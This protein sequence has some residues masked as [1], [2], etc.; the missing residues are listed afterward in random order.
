MLRGDDQGIAR[1]VP[2]A[3]CALPP[4][5][6]ATAVRAPSEA[7]SAAWSATVIP[8]LPWEGPSA[9]TSR[10][11]PSAVWPTA[12]REVRLPSWEPVKPSPEVGTAFPSL[13]QQRAAA[14]GRDRARRAGRRGPGTGLR[15]GRG[16]TPRPMP[17]RRSPPR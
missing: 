3:S 1:L 8:G 14:E 10:V 11:V 4:A 9:V 17:A 15:A 5:S 2:T 16:G 13:H 12:E 7:S 6:M